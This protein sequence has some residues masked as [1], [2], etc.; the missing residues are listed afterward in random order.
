VDYEEKKRKFT[1]WKSSI[2]TN[3]FYWKDLYS[4]YFYSGEKGFAYIPPD[5]GNY[6][7]FNERF[8]QRY[9]KSIGSNE[10]KM[11]ILGAGGVGKS[12]LVLQYIQNFFAEEYDPT[13][14]DSYR[15]QIKIE[16][17]S[18]IIEILDTAGPEEY[19][20]M[21]D[22]WM[23]VGQGFIVTYSL[24][25]K[26]SFQEVSV[27]IAQILRVQEVDTAPI[28]IVGNKCDLYAIQDNVQVSRQEGIDLAKSLNVPFF[29][30]SALTRINVDE[31][32]RTCVKEIVYDPKS[33]I[34]KV[35][36]QKNNCI[37]Q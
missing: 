13:I 33:N 34:D 28:I 1:K 32:F 8:L 5:R 2:N 37:I 24:N 16:D 11:V 25:S 6:K 17:N 31:L 22:Q 9:P 29:E 23:R 21:R 36:T 27:F 14:E 18:M 15:K 35:T 30:A 20:A 4:T 7:H 3:K 10:F 12:C 26:Q 19:S